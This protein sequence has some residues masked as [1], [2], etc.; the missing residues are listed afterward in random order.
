MNGS[1]IFI[2]TVCFL[3]LATF[4]TDI[5][6]QRKISNADRIAHE[7]KLLA[8]IF[9]KID[10]SC[11]ILGFDQEINSINFLNVKSFTGSE[12]GPVN[13]E[14]PQHWAG[15]Y[16]KDNPTMQ[17]IEYQVVKNKYGYFVTPGNGVKL[18]NGKII[19]KDIQLNESTDINALMHDKD[20]LFY[21]GKPLAAVIKLNN[22]T[23]NT[24]TIVAVEE[25]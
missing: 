4:F 5:W 3:L 8:S 9:E 20:A 13:L 18:P 24:N 10:A 14:Y 22:N 19:G 25:L 2:G 11:T 7:V 15:P 21:K 12:V 16:L 23:L 6:Y 17:S 1:R